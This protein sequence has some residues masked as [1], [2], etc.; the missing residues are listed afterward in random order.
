MQY[1]G[2]NEEPL[3][4]VYFV[5]ENHGWAVGNMS[6]ILHT[7]DGGN[8]WT[9]QMSGTGYQFEDVYFVNPDT[10]WVVGL[11][12][13]LQH[14]AV[15]FSTVDG[16]TTWNLQTFGSDDSF[17][18]VQFVND[19]TGWVVG[20]S[21]TEAIVFHTSDGGN[22]WTSQTPGTSNFLSGVSFVDEDNG[23]AVGFNGTIIHTSTGGIVGIE[24]DDYTASHLPEKFMLYDNYPNPFNPATTIRYAL[25]VQ[26]Q[27]TLKIYNVLGKEIRTLVRG[28]QPAGENSVVWDS[29][30]NFDEPVGSGVYIY[31]LK[32]QNTILSK[33]MI[34]IR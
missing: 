21:N 4:A 27:I 32:T 14:F 8:N 25:P 13:S 28:I 22:N 23:W 20:G 31:Q 12:L 15:I 29:R 34:L 5:D 2:S 17:Q 11:D 26:S 10:G 24:D 3:D 33:K 19:S 7:S 16:G 1:S 30:N 18:G 6:A 9:T